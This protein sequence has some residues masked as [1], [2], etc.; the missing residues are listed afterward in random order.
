MLEGEFTPGVVNRYVAAFQRA[1]AEDDATT[2]KKRMHGA[3]LEYL[4]L[5]TL[6]PLGQL[7]DHW[8]IVIDDRVK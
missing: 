2:A 4:F 5:D 3:R 7:I 8:E 6:N 1:R